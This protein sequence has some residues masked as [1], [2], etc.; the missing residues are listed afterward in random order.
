VPAQDVSGYLYKGEYADIAE[1]MPKGTKKTMTF[2]F[3]APQEFLFPWTKTLWQQSQ[4][5]PKAFMGDDWSTLYA[6]ATALVGA[7]LNCAQDGDV[8]AYKLPGFN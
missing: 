4:I 3:K 1:A 7:N 2:I 8:L 6:G 5:P